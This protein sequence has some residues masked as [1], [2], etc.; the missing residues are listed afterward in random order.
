[1]FVVLNCFVARPFAIDTEK[2]SIASAIAI[3]NVVM[4]IGLHLKIVA[5]SNQFLKVFCT[6]VSEKRKFVPFVFRANLM[7]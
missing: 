2:E 1:M 6:F 4:S 7:F 5:L 3:S